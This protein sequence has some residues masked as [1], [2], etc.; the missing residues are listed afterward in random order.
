MRIVKSGISFFIFSEMREVSQMVVKASSNLNLNFTQNY[1][2][3]AAFGF[4]QKSFDFLRDSVLRLIEDLFE[5]ELRQTAEAE[6]RDCGGGN[7]A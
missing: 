3:G 4:I 2:F 1:D 6:V 7:R 5:C